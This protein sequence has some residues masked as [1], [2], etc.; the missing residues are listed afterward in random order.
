[1]LTG[2]NNAA[3]VLS[4]MKS[5]KYPTEQYKDVQS[6]SFNH[7]K[8]DG[9][10]ALFLKDLEERLV[11]YYKETGQTTTDEGS[12]DEWG[13]D[14]TDDEERVLSYRIYADSKD[15]LSKLIIA[16]AKDM[17]ANRW[18]HFGFEIKSLKVVPQVDN[19]L[20]Q[21]VRWIKSK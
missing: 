17:P 7:T 8:D 1:M 15:D 18:R 5:F 4:L 2:T 19:G 11:A 12:A 20:I 6:M 3:F 13:L 9:T 10:H 16:A 21:D 14:D